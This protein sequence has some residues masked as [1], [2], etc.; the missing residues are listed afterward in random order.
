M[1]VAGKKLAE[2]DYYKRMSGITNIMK[3]ISEISPFQEGDE[4]L[5][6]DKK[7]GRF[8]LLCLPLLDSVVIL[9]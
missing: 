6:R 9:V 3:E 4:M 7:L 1:Y 8:L 5:I 2:G